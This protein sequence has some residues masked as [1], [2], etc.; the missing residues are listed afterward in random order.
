MG[1]EL[2]AFSAKEYTCY[3]AKVLDEKVEEAFEIITDM[4]LRPLMRPRDVDAERKVILEEI[5]MHEDSPDDII[6]DLFVSAL[7]ES[8]P[9]GQSAPMFMAPWGSPVILSMFPF[10]MCTRTPQS[11]RQ[12]AQVVRTTPFCGILL[13]LIFSG[14]SCFVAAIP[15]S[16]SLR[17][18]SSA[19]GQLKVTALSCLGCGLLP[20]FPQFR[21]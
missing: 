14:A 17:H 1:G 16:F 9:L 7:W 18:A 19:P 2:N 13:G 12:N 6:H 4:L 11:W 21:P 8:H 5:A 15:V 20:P 10:F 3:Y